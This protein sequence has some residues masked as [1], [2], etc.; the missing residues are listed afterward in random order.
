MDC[1][2]GVQCN[3]FVLLAGDQVAARS[4]VAMKHSENKTRLLGSATAMAFCGEPGDGQFF[5]DYA[6]KRVRLQSIL[7]GRELSPRATARFLRS[8]LAR[9]LRTQDVRQVN[10]L[11]GGCDR[12][13]GAAQLFWLDYL[14]T[15]VQTPYAAHGYGAYF[16]LSLMDRHYRADMALEE[17]LALLRMCFNELKARF[18]VSLPSFAVRAICRDGTSRE[19]L[20]SV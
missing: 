6:E 1:L 19:L 2:F 12:Q 15:M 5:S 17:G 13:A 4:I 8:E 11:V 10:L 18:I 7:D 9:R 3:D 16:C 14:G 20:V